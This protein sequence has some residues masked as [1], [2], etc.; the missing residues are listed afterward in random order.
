MARVNRDDM[1]SAQPRP[2]GCVRAESL[3]R[4]YVHGVEG[5]RCILL[6][7]VDELVVDDIG[8]CVRLLRL[9]RSGLSSLAKYLGA[10]FLD[11]SRRQLAVQIVHMHGAVLRASA[12]GVCDDRFGDVAHF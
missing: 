7:R 12:S 11:G 9:P 4:L 2:H 3:D 1:L 6:A 5:Y 8:P 10:N